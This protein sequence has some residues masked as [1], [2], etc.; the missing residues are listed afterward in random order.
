MWM[1]AIAGAVPIVLWLVLF[2]VVWTQI[3]AL[4]GRL[5]GVERRRK[6]APLDAPLRRGDFDVWEAHVTRQ[7]A[8]AHTRIDLL[9]RQ[10][11]ELQ[12]TATTLASPGSE[13][14]SAVYEIIGAGL[15]RL[16]SFSDE[17]QEWG[18]SGKTKLNPAPPQ[19]SGGVGPEVAP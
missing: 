10:L 9:Q 12:G 6:V 15:P 7:M 5:D 13:R 3:D 1:Y 14:K 4:S 18:M 16:P 17:S 2:C 11:T 8:H 19:G